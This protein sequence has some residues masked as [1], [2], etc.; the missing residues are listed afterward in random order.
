M[1]YRQSRIALKWRICNFDISYNTFFWNVILR[2]QDSFNSEKTFLA[3]KVSANMKSLNHIFF[4]QKVYWQQQPHL[5]KF[6]HNFRFI[7]TSPIFFN[8]VPSQNQVCERRFTIRLTTNGWQVV[9]D[10]NNDRKKT[11]WQR[12]LGLHF[13]P[14]RQSAAWPSSSSQKKY[15]YNQFIALSVTVKIKLL[16]PIIDGFK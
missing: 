3:E 9:N 12:D 16:L 10:N 7:F 13:F 14:I 15:A 2:A 11:K 8:T 1:K 6:R 5:A 4:W